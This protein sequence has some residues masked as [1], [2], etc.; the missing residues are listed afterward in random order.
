MPARA[1]FSQSWSLG[2]V[3]VD[4]ERNKICEPVALINVSPGALL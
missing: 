1:S 3:D 4:G 2:L